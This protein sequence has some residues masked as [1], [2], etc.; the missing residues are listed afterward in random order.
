MKFAADAPNQRSGSRVRN[1]FTANVT[2]LAWIRLGSTLL[3]EQMRV[4]DPV[5]MRAGV[6]VDSDADPLPISAA[7][8]R[9]GFS[10]SAV[11]CCVGRYFVGQ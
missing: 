10:T 1:G 6:Q 3:S 2:V 8:R 5:W 4:A 9:A 11:F 7:V